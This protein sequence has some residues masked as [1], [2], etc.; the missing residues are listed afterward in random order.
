M[1]SSDEDPSPGDLKEEDDDGAVPLAFVL[2]SKSRAK[3]PNQGYG[4]MRIERAQSCS[5]L[6]SYA[7]IMCTNLEGNFS[8]ST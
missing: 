1:P 5:L 8:L 6:R 7:L 2:G 3:N 4:I